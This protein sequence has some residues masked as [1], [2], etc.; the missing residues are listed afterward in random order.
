MFVVS[1][2][3]IVVSGRRIAC[4]H[5]ELD[6]LFESDGRSRNKPRHPAGKV[7]RNFSS[8]YVILPLHLELLDGQF[9]LKHS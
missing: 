5:A 9:W 6:S 4:V 8:K 2:R 7:G 3:G 1:G